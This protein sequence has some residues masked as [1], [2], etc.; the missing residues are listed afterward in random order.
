MKSSPHYS[1]EEFIEMVGLTC[2]LLCCC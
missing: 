2:R 1:K